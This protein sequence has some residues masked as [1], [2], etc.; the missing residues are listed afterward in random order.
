MRVAQEFIAQE[1]IAQE[2]IAQECIP[3]NSCPR[4]FGHIETRKNRL[5]GNLVSHP[6]LQASDQSNMAASSKGD[7]YLLELQD[8][9]RLMYCGI[10]A[11]DETKYK[12]IE[13]NA[14]LVLNK[15]RL[16]GEAGF[17]DLILEVEGRQLTTH[18]CVLAANSQFFYTM[19]SSGMKESNQTLLSLK[20]VSFQS[21]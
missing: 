11:A 12:G 4:D 7:R 13:S 10:Y 17:C 16:E 18:R 14:L 2:C 15:F 5:G 3:G 1:C 9:E 8:K 21:M 20:S 6:S 19:F